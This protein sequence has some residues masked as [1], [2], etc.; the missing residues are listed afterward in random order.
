MVAGSG[1]ELRASQPHAS[2][3]VIIKITSYSSPV[4]KHCNLKISDKNLL[5]DGGSI[6]VLI[7]LCC[8]IDAILISVFSL[9]R[10]QQNTGHF[11]NNLVL[12]ALLY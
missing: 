5:F 6:I 4:V 10:Y 7:E 2:T 9:P 11:L 8:P 12:Q 1:T 3:V